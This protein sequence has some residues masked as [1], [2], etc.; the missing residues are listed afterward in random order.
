[1]SYVQITRRTF[2]C[3]RVPIGQVPFFELNLEPHEEIVKFDVHSFGARH[4]KTED[5]VATA[6]VLNRLD[7]GQAEGVRDAD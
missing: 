1:M 2:R 7:Q 5:Y 3:D 6:W 4:R